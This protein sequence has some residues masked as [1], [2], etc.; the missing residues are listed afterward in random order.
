M[1]VF[2]KLQLQEDVQQADMDLQEVATTANTLKEQTETIKSELQEHTKVSLSLSS[3]MVI[4]PVKNFTS[5]LL[6]KIQVNCHSC[7]SR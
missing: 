6:H 1:N 3:S 5:L 7:N 2:S 4:E